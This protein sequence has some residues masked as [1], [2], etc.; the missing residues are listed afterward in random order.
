[1]SIYK[2]L[3]TTFRVCKDQHRFAPRNILSFFGRFQGFSHPIL[4][5]HFVIER[6]SPC[7]SIL[8]SYNSKPN[9]FVKDSIVGS[10]RKTICASL[11]RIE[12]QHSQNSSMKE[13]EHTKQ[14]FAFRNW[15][16]ETKL[17]RLAAHKENKQCHRSVGNKSVQKC[18]FWDTKSTIGKIRS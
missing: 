18:G 13:W 7:S 12:W 6:D 17:K 5:F 3:E 15:G 14:R 16:V 4:G 1:M 8:M 11:C 9:S 2:L 10:I